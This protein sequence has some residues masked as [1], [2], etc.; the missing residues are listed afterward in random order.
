M[1][2]QA[3]VDYVN[4]ILAAVKLQPHSPA[5]L[6][7]IEQDNDAIEIDCYSIQQTGG[8]FVIYEEYI[9]QGSYWEPDVPDVAEIGEANSLADAIEF[10]VTRIMRNW[11]RDAMRCESEAALADLDIE[12]EDVPF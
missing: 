6:W 5:F 11:V 3:D 2:T 10:I 1:F 7:S 4:K 9:I 12:Q 8:K